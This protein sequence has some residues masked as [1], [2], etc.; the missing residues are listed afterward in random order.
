MLA[1]APGEAD[2]MLANSLASGLPALNID[3][4]RSGSRQDFGGSKLDQNS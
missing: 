4:C 2:R 3:Y 1:V